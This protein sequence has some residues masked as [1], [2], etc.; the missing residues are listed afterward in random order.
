MVLPSTSG[1]AS[2][3]RNGPAPLLPVRLT[4]PEILLAP[5]SSPPWLFRQGDAAGDGVPGARVVTRV[6]QQ[7]EAGCPRHVHRLD[8]RIADAEAAG[9]AGHDAA[10]DRGVGDDGA[11]D[12]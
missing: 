12:G 10:A 7:H 9:I 11:G 1:A 3:G 8:A 6:A 5:I 4:V 2:S